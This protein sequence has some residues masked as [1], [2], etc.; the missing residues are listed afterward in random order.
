MS[1]FIVKTKLSSLTKA[2][3]EQK[4]IMP[5]IVEAVEQYATLGEVVDS[6]KEVYGEWTEKIAF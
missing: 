2:C 6:M 1:K 5:F 4:N 3:K